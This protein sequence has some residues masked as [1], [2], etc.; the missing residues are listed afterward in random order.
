MIFFWG[1]VKI[2]ETN[3]L[4]NFWTGVT[5]EQQLGEAAYKDRADLQAVGEGWPRAPQTTWNSRSQLTGIR[6]LIGHAPVCSRS[7]HPSI[8]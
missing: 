6:G 7:S 3:W 2:R 5:E 1:E 4:K 8:L